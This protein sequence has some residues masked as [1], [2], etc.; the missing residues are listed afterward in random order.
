MED[1]F[2]EQERYENAKK[3]VS[4]LRGFYTH[5]V[6]YLVINTFLLIAQFQNLHEGQ[7]LFT[8]GNFSTALF[9]G[10]GLVAHAASVFVP[11]WAFTRKWEERK[12]K[13][14][15]DRDRQNWE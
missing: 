2:Y 14:L 13:E 15:M 9:W 5:L 3:E 1:N 7:S 8:F 6:V 12:I 11:R 10:I 4:K